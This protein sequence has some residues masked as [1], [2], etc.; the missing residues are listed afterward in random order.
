MRNVLEVFIPGVTGFYLLT[1]LFQNYYSMRS[2]IVILEKQVE[3]VKEKIS[4]L[5]LFKLKV[6]SND[7]M[8]GRRAWDDDEEEEEEED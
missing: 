6:Y 2:R 8:L 5:E 3:L 7:I 4:D 1:S